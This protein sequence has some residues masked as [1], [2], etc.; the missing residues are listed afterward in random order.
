MVMLRQLTREP[1]LAAGISLAILPPA[2][3]HFLSSEK[4]A[5]GGVAHALFVGA[6]V[7]EILERGPNRASTANERSGKPQRSEGK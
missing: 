1:V 7:D 4:V 2:L 6:S 3:L 5:W